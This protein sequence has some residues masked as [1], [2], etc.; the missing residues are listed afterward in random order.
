[1]TE[2]LSH[3]PDTIPSD[4]NTL[5][6]VYAL[7]DT[8]AP[9]TGVSIESLLEHNCPEFD[10]I[11]IH[12]LCNGV[13]ELNRSRLKEVV[14]K[15]D[16]ITQT[17]VAIR[18]YDNLQLNDFSGLPI[19]STWPLASWLRILIPEVLPE[20]VTRCLYLDGD[21]IITGSL[22]PLVDV[23][24]DSHDVAGI[25]NGCKNGVMPEW[26]DVAGRKRTDPYIAS[27]FLLFNPQFW[28]KK[29][30]PARILDFAKQHEATLHYPDMDA[31][32][33]ALENK[34]PLNEKLTA[35][36]WD[37]VEEA[38]S[39]SNKAGIDAT[40]L[41]IIYHYNGGAYTRGYFL[42]LPHIRKLF[43]QYKSQTPWRDCPNYL[44]NGPI[45]LLKI[46]VM[47]LLQRTFFRRWYTSFFRLYVKLIKR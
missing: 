19:S 39:A 10:G 1:M 29:Q 24:V 46:F 6:C 16:T 21:I 14:Q 32:N 13:S 25:A 11:T 18:Y 43:Q 38:L 41:P 42:F 23:D 30:Y 27:G 31:I 44:I 37:E 17:M 3:K 9:L 26:T 33:G 12:L 4:A 45:G 40:T 35:L 34:L 2:H 7:D 36:S 47:F 20:N 22:R 8:F 28:R 5:D 15:Y